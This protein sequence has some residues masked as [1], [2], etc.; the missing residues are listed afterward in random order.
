MDRM[1][2]QGS[3]LPS[4]AVSIV[5]NLDTVK[6]KV[7]NPQE[8]LSQELETQEDFYTWLKLE[9]FNSD[10]LVENDVITSWNMYVE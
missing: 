7:D 3:R 9:D 8:I 1:L 2:S 5:K 10:V 6:N 4:L